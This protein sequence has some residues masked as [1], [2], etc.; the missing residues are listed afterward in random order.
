MSEWLATFCP[1]AVVTDARKIAE[2]YLERY[3]KKSDFIPYG[4][5]T[6]KLESAA[7][8]DGFGLERERLFSLRQP[9]GAGEQRASGARGVRASADAAQA[10]AHW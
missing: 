6:G 10:G 7:V 2:Y 3:G 1:N 8:L 4:A 9:D 5:E